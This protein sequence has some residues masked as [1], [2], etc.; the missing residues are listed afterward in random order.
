MSQNQYAPVPPAPPSPGGAVAD[1]PGRTLSIVGLI[2]AFVLPLIGLILSIVAMN[3]SKRAGYRNALARWGVIVAIIVM[4]L[5]LV[6]GIVSAI[7]G[8]LSAS[9]SYGY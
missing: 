6:I 7:G 2:L 4:A 9:F 8:A 3:Q 1:D 5:S